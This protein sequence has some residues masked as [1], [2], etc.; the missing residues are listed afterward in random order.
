[1]PLVGD[2]AGA[3]ALRAVGDWVRRQDAVVDVFYVSN[4][5]QYLFQQGDA[6]DNSTRTSPRCR[7]AAARCSSGRSRIAV[8][9]PRQHP[10]A[11]SSSVTSPIDDVL[12]LYPDWPVADAM[13]TSSI[14]RDRNSIGVRA[15]SRQSSASEQSVERS[16]ALEPLDLGLPSDDHQLP[17]IERDGRSSAAPRVGC[18]GTAATSRSG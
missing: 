3:K 11:R 10:Y 6:G 12:G 13:R 18:H 14:C 4:V 9:R 5:E 15:H 1:M 16:D 8:G 17:P 2:F 7:A